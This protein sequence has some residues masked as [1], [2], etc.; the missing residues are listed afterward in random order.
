SVKDILVKSSNIGMAKIGER[1]TNAGLY[2][3]A[4]RFGF[5]RRTG[6]G[7]PG[8]LDGLLRP[9]KDWTGY[10][11]GS[12]PM[13]QEL[14]VTPLQL[15]A[16]HA[17]LANG[18]TLRAPRLARRIGPA[19]AGQ[20]PESSPATTIPAAVTSR[21]V[22]HQTANWIVREAMTDVVRR[23]TGKRARLPGYEVF[24][25]TGTAQKTDRR[26]GRYFKNRH[27]CLFVA[28]APADDPRVLVLVVVD[29]PTA[30][31]VHYGGTVAAPTAA[32]IL[33]QSLV[34]LGVPAR[35]ARKE[36]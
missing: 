24:G 21:V 13:G 5:G 11:T 16:A 4:A 7:L 18:G 36:R 19:S 12:I 8:E 10:S 22:A 31:G 32:R 35:V 9:L 33:R 27:V 28:G 26:T 23:G 20:I 34:H 30:A 6:S 2:A 1:L 15:I 17:A 14:A 3:A 29:E 25:K